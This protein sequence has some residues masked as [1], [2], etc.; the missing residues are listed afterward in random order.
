MLDPRIYRAALIPIVF[1]LIVG[2]FSLS[3]RPRPIGTTL[4]PGRGLFAPERPI[5]HGKEPA[6]SEEFKMF[7]SD[8]FATS[9]AATRPLPDYA[10]ANDARGSPSRAPLALRRYFDSVKTAESYCCSPADGSDALP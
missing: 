8:L 4:E 1:A 5:G 2:A 9:S 3:D 10:H 6:A 7:Y